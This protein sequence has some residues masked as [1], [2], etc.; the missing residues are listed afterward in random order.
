MKDY[1]VRFVNFW[2]SFDKADNIFLDLLEDQGLS[3]SVSSDRSQNVDLEIVSVFPTRKE[4]LAKKA[5]QILVGKNLPFS[6]IE[7]ERSY[8]KPFN[9]NAT[10][11]IWYTGENVRPPLDQEFDGFLSFDQGYSSEG[12]AYFPLWMHDLGWF[13]KPRFNK[14]LGKW[15]HVEDLTKGRGRPKNSKNGFCAFVGNPDP[16]RLHAIEK[17]SQ[18]FPA[19]L[20]GSFFGNPVK[21]KVAVASQY[22][23]MVCF[24]NDLYPGYVSE[25]IVEAYLA[26]TIPLYWGDF[27]AVDANVFNMDSLLNLADFK[28]VEEFMNRAQEIDLEWEKIYSEP[29]LAK[30]PQLEAIKYVLTGI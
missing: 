27:G 2:S 4:T 17:L 10:R 13:A 11:R 7:I 6:S 16:I 20:F 22:K 9:A 26:D 8:R 24:E 18:R 3:V 23:F 5:G 30:K 28:S 1:Q 25:K 21:N 15:C 12:N 29:L 19:G 14:R